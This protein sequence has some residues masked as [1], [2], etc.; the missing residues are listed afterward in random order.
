MFSYLKKIIRHTQR[1]KQKQ[2]P[3]Q[4]EDTEQASEPDTNMAGILEIADCEFKTT[5]MNML[6][7]SVEKSGWVQEWMGNISTEMDDL[8]KSCKEMLEIRNTVIETKRWRKRVK[9]DVVILISKQ[10]SRHEI[11]L[12]IKLIT[13]KW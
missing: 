9:T 6:R 4:F 5:M 1:W 10:M 2:K 7:A 11:L 3:T 12:A 8:R 13:S